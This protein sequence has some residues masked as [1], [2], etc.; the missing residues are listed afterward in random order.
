[1]QR[2]PIIFITL[3]YLTFLWSCQPQKDFTPDELTIIPRPEK[4][5]LKEGSFLFDNNT[6]FIVENEEQKAIAVQ[7]A[8]KFEKA[9]GFKPQVII[10]KKAKKN[11][12]LFLSGTVPGDEAYLLDVMDGYIQITASKPAGFF[13]GIQTL[14]QLLPVEI[15]SKKQVTDINWWIPNINISDNPRFKWRGFLQDVSRH[16]LPKEYIMELID[17]LSYH[18]IN[19]LHLHLTDDQGWR[20]EIKKYP[21]LTE[22]GAWRVD[23][24]DKHWM[25]RP[26]QK[27]GE[28]ATYGG[29]YTQEDIKEIVA[30]GQSRQVTILPEIEMPAHSRAAMASYPEFSCTGGPFTVASG[31]SAPITDIFCAGNDAAFTFQEDVLTE[32]MELF[33]SEY[34]HI[35][36][37]EAA[38]AEWGKCPKC[39]KRV[40]TEGLEN[41]DELQSYFIKRIEK[42]LISK[43][44]KLI[45][46]D[47]ILKG[48]L[49]PEATV[50][51][52]RGIK[53]GIEAAEQ[54]HDVIMTP[55]SDTYVNMYQGQKDME[56]YAWGGYLPLSRIYAFDP[57]KS[58]SEKAA[59]HVLGGQACLWSEY[60]TEKEMAMYMTF[61]RLAA[62]AETLWTP[63]ELKDWPDF[64]RR[65]K[66]L[67]NRYDYLGINYAKSA[68]LVSSNIKM[69]FE[70]KTVSLALANEFPN[71]DIRY[72][73][74]D[75][76]LGSNSNKYTDTIKISETTVIKSAVI[77]NDKVKGKTLTHAIKFH[78]AVEKKVKYKGPIPTGR[79][80]GQELN[81]TNAIRGTQNFDDGHWQGWYNKDMEIVIDLENEQL[82]KKVSVGTLEDQTWKIYFPIAVEVLT[83]IDGK[84]FKKQGDIKRA[85]SPG[86]SSLKDFVV[87]INPTTAKF[88]KVKA[89]NLGMS[90]NNKKRSWLFVDEIIVE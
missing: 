15:E 78:K 45:G 74:G 23:H 84:S 35:G 73:L 4:M 9:A 68:Y 8:D 46:W 77:E 88:V 51:S 86:D 2:K 62:L 6:K 56:P 69:S 80:R 47:E 87:N 81:L 22:V 41:V 89:T 44:R 7:L 25:E 85:Y 14:R 55:M 1:M 63:K 26:E 75:E 12:V 21:K 16:F 3:L 54:G 32:V 71:S 36:G 33:P 42:F 11:S 66:S 18:K 40:H 50:M 61:P 83:S 65:V 53:G 39:K 76:E 37:D 60:V 59:K 67:F 57:Q 30:F 17:Y 48:G 82:V 38:K 13:Y 43:G 31:G 20:I 5:E 34:I 49:A 70:D 29:F 19:T 64:S 27:E 24:N 72:V 58:M 52:W 90:R 28:K 79:Y 10:G